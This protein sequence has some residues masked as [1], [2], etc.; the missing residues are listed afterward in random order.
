MISPEQKQVTRNEMTVKWHFDDGYIYF[1]LVSPEKGWVAI[2]FNESD[3]LKDTYLLMGSISPVGTTVKEYHVFRP[4][5][6][7]SFES[8]REPESVDKIHGTENE[9][10][11][12]IAFRLP[13]TS[14]FQY[15]KQL[16]PENELFLTMAYSLEDNFDHHSI[17][18]TSVKIKL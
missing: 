5:D 6:Y 13:Q 7:Q 17:M 10:G 1:E 8:I 12:K 3:A 14:F 11:T 2:G 9:N 18:R 16:E 4:G 15:A